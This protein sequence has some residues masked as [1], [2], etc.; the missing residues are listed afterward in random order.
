MIVLMAALNGYLARFFSAVIGFSRVSGVAFV[1]GCA[2]LAISRVCQ[3]MAFFLP[4]KIFIVIHSG[5][6]PDYFN[7]FPETMGF[8]EI[9]VLLSVMVPVV[10]GLF[11]ALGIVYRWLIDLHLKRFDSNVLVIM[12]KETPNNKMKRLHNHVSKAFSEAGLVIVSIAVAVFL[13]LGV[14]IAW[15]VLIYANLWLFHKKAFGAEDHDRLTFLNLHRRQFIEYISSANFLV[16][17]AV[18]AIEL[19]YFDM[20]VYTAIFLLLVSRMVFQALNR[21]SVESLYILKALP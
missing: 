18:L 13:D 16:V 1:V 17:F 15:F 5:E 12:G 8:R 3:V 9:I 6:V 11:I 21:F 4:L 2:A 7:I 20:G 10:Y 14:A 19:V